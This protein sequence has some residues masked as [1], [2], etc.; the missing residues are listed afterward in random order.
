MELVRTKPVQQRMVRTR[1]L[2]SKDTRLLQAL[3]NP[4]AVQRELNNRS[5]YQFLQYFWPLVSSHPFS[6]NWH[7]ELL[8][9]ELEQLAYQV[10]SR[11][12]RK[13][14][15]IINVPPGSTKT[16]TCS[17]MF[18][19][20]CWTKWYWMRF[21][22]SSYSAPLSL[23]S[24]GYSRDIIQ[25]E[26][27]QE[28]YPE[29]EI[30]DDKN[31]LT[32]FRIVKKLGG[33]NKQEL[34][35][36][37]RY[38]TSVGG[39]LTGFHGD[40]LLV[41]DPLNPG[42]AAS[43]TEIKTANHWVEQTLSTRKTDK[44]VTPTIII[45]Q[46]LHQDD[47]SGHMLAKNKANIKHI[48]LPGECLHYKEQVNPAELIKFYKDDLLDP[49][50]MPWNVLKDMEA[51]L[52]QYG[53][54]G[55]IGQNPVPPGGGMF[56]VDHFSI[57]DTLPTRNHIIKSVRYWDK[58]GTGKVTGGK[59]KARGAFTAGVKMHL[60]SNGFYVVSDVKRGRWE[61]HERE[62][63]IRET[64]EADGNSVDVWTEQEPGSGGKESAQG[65]IRN[66]AGFRAFSETSTGEK[67]DRA[68]PF[69]VQVNNGNVFLLRGSWNHDFIEEYRFFPFGSYKDQVDAGSGAFNKLVQKKKAKRIT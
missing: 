38:S 4:G 47:P 64:A 20:W 22:C 35:G 29:L 15:L 45:M 61:T 50:R 42:Q 17:I 18:P 23:E 55:Q 2:P 57:M 59:G 68:D 66:L 16:I 39:T 63:I 58:A 48:S 19:V 14:D 27:F 46:R 34:S 30:K 51:D 6:P 25:S 32:N 24:A 67:A 21:I 54:S 12:P 41:D 1:S 43:D 53:Y 9:S 65:T 7:I 3:Q 36:G 5:L 13:Y 10:A 31:K 69:S 44:A 52:G 28:L 49:N 56:K 8:C 40:I 37:S 33:R 26:Q 11:E 60:L 62:D